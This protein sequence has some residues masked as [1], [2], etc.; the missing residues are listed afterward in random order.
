MI[1]DLKL[2][3]LCTILSYWGDAKVEAYIMEVIDS[4]IVDIVNIVVVD[5]LAEQR[6]ML[7]K[8]M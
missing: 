4:N 2:K 8:P 7:P 1:W 5:D 6:D 3:D